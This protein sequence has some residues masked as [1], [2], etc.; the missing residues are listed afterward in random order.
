MKKTLFYFL[1]AALCTVNFT[2]CSSDNGDD[3]KDT[4][5][6]PEL[7]T[8]TWM[9]EPTVMYD[10]NGNV[11]TNE[12]EINT[13]TGSVK[14][15]WDCPEGTSLKLGEG[16][17]AIEMPIA[18]IKTLV[19]NL[20]NTK[21]P[22]VLKSVEFKTNGQI[23]ALY[24]DATTTTSYL[25]AGTDDWKVASNYATYKKVNKNKILVYLNVSAVT[26]GMGADEKAALTQILKIFKDGV[27]V[28][29]RWTDNNKA[30][31]YVDKTFIT[32]L[33][34]NAQL[35]ALV[36]SL[37]DEDLNGMAPMV[38]AAVSAVKDVMNKTTTFEAGLELQK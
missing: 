25:A 7:T 13:S 24:K 19:E 18:S 2:A 30:Y 23:V 6:F 34:D 26:E 20:G 1:L 28:N 38:K 36:N 37:S 27:P 31:F 29:I 9:L 21:L 35:K 33:M 11:T 16:D 17:E 4:V 3:D 15:T 12:D 32:S 14:V 22:T 5:D 8:G 10:A